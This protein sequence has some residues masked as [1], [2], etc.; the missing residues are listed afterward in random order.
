MTG[1]EDDFHCLTPLPAERA[2]VWF[3]GPFEGREVRWHLA[4]YTLRAYCREYPAD[5]PRPP[6]AFIDIQPRANDDAAAPSELAL[7]VGLN[8]PCID[9]PAI[10]KTVIMLRNYQ[11]LHLGR[12]T[13]GEPVVVT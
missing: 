12:H 1:P 13:F 8:L 6:R 11:R 3:S 10:R 5:C 2:E 4:L 7:S 9:R